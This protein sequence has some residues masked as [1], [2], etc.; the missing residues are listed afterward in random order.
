MDEIVVDLEDSVAPDA[1]ERARE[2]VGGFLATERSFAV[3]V[4]VRINPLSGAWGERDVVEPV[5]QVGPR[6]GSLV[7]PKV[8]SAEDV[9]AVDRL[10]GSVGEPAGGVGLQ[11]LVETAGG[12][13]RAGEIAA[14]SPRL[15]ALILGY[16]DLAAS[17]GRAPGPT[18]PERWSHAQ[19]T[20]LVAARAA[21]IQAIDGP[22][23]EIRDDAGLRLRA[24]HAR[25]L[26]FD[27][28]WAVHP[29]Q[30]GIINAA[31][32]PVAEE[33]ARARAIL[34]ALAGAE[35]R[36]AVELD[37]EMID[38][39]SRKLALQVIARG[40]AAGIDGAPW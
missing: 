34:D 11:A 26:G 37:G 9:L 38:E 5:E 25:A 39:A 3:A 2:L 40:R 33:L 7:I 8:E 12:L 4:A 24:E 28:K 32:T 36:G 18:P 19:E 30:L 17:L 1:K 29:R 10:L 20:L 13:L 31:F 21:G 22:Y 35:G 15:E 14:S 23:L 27:G 16:A 6:I